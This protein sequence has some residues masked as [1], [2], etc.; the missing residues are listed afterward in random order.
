MFIWIVRELNRILGDDGTSETTR[1]IGVL[2]MFGFE[3]QK[4]NSFE[5]LCI[6]SA[7]EHLQVRQL[8]TS[9]LL[10]LRSHTHISTV[11]LAIVR[12]LSS[13]NTYSPGRRG[14][15]KRKGSP[16]LS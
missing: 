7:N 6:N 12:S 3:S 8:L 5:Q 10:F 13:T 15:S 4:V 11:Q 9:V 16:A 1:E 2:D 14:S